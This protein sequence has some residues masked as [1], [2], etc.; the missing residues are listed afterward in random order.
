MVSSRVVFEPISQARR[1]RSK[2]FVPRTTPPS[3]RQPD[4]RAK[5]AQV[6]LKIVGMKEPPL[7]LFGKFGPFS[8]PNS[9]VIQN[10][11]I[12]ELCRS[13][14][15]WK[16][17]ALRFGMVCLY[18]QTVFYSEC[19]ITTMLIFLVKINNPLAIDVMQTTNC[20]LKTPN[21]S[22]INVSNAG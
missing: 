17:C 11:V 18:R 14:Q 12:T 2:T 20:S 16:W 22:A 7:R 15:S 3:V 1:R 4:F 5:A 19:A 9:E 10:L 6:I 13:R 8:C 21:A